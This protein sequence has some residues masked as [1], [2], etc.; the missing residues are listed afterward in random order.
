MS[1]KI[2]NN[3]NLLL[4]ISIFTSLIFSNCSNIEFKRNNTDFYG[5]AM[6]VKGNK[7]GESTSLTD[8]ITGMFDNGDFNVSNNTNITYEVALKQF[9]IMPLV[10]ADKIGGTIIT[11]WYSASGNSDER[12]KFNIFVLNEAMD[13]TSIDIKMFKE[14]FNG[15]N[16]TATSIDD[17][18]PIQIKNLIL[19]KSR[20]L[21]VTA[22]LS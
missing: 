8:R 4:I 7:P 14:V 20:Q 22:E 1:L 19:K 10:S 15:T 5:E 6:E 18:T 11:D 2:P 17:N 21:K 9:S 16:W 12:F 3:H 13:D